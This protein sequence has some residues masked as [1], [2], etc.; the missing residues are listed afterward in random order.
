MRISLSLLRSDHG[1]AT[2]DLL[3]S[4]ETVKHHAMALESALSLG[5]CSYCLRSRRRCIESLRWPTR[6]WK[7]HRRTQYRAR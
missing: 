6:S 3:R 5:L 1:L 2:I 7:D 4:R